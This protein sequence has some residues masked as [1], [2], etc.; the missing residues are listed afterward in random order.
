MTTTFSPETERPLNIIV[1]IGN[2]PRA[3][4]L[5]LLSVGMALMG[6]KNSTSRLCLL[7]VTRVKDTASLSLAARPA[8][9]LRQ[10]LE[11]L[12]DEY[13]RCERL[14][15]GVAARD[16]WPD[17]FNLVQTRSDPSDLLLMPWHSSRRYL[18]VDLPAALEKPPSDIA[19]VHPSRYRQRVRRI[20]LPVRGGSFSL[21]A[22]RLAIQL[23]RSYGAEITLMHVVDGNSPLNQAAL[24][25]YEALAGAYP[26]F[27]R[28]MQVVGKAEQAIAREL[29]RHQILIIGAS[30][31]PGAPISKLA[32]RMLARDDMT[33]IVVRTMAPLALPASDPPARLPTSLRVDKWFA[34]NTFHCR[35]FSDIGR[36]IDLKRRQGLTISVGLPALNEE[37]T[38]GRVIGAIKG[39]LM[40]DAPLVDEIVLI[41]SNS[42][43]STREIAESMGVPWHIHQRTMTRLGARRG[44][45]EALWK[46][47]HA[48]KGDLIAWIDTD[49]E[50]PDP[51]FVFGVLGPLLAR[52][53][54]QYVK[55]FYQRPIHVDGIRQAS[56]GGR[57][58]EL[59]ARPMINLFFPELSGLVQP[60]SGEY[61][62]RRAALERVPFYSGYGVETGLLLDLLEMFGLDAIAQVDLE[63][64]VHRN[65]ALHA[66]S[67]MSFALLQVFVEHLQNR[68]H[69]S[70]ALSIERSMKILRVENKGYYLEEVQI[71]E[72]QRPPI[73]DIPE[74][75]RRRGNPTAE[76]TSGP[77]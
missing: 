11:S 56:G 39:P 41:D 23:A 12:A 73:I 75:R 35:E 30:A 59:L 65:Q 61:A 67:R 49:I 72:R 27:T 16:P 58:T 14:P 36:L 74:Y 13:P 5:K 70:A 19:V 28:Q 66:L 24:E 18:G 71:H 45:G 47:L 20:L 10:A 68:Q 40:D 32:E 53:Q 33:T 63:E 57:V 51:R 25:R 34:E 52:P 76:L 7:G 48:L 2:L 21:L 22:E 15:V 50:N 1:P 29:E 55:G 3:R 54:I 42:S 43:D 9:A 77:Q 64:R 31:A 46:S 17:I 60:L 44:K 8:Q 38:I 6:A 62:G 37:E 4:S 26:E 69:V